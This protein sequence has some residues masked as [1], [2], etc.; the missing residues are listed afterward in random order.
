MLASASSRRVLE[1]IRRM[2][3]RARITRRRRSSRS[4]P[5]R[6]S[7]VLLPV[8]ATVGLIL[9]LLGV[10][11]ALRGLGVSSMVVAPTEEQ[12]VFIDE[13][14]GVARRLRHEVG[15]AP[16]LVTAMA[17][18]ESGW[19]QSSLTRRAH[20]YFGI[21]AEV[22]QGSMG[23]VLEP[24]QEVLGGRTITVWSRFRAYRSLEESVR[25]LGQFLHTNPR[26]ADLW[27]RAA[28][29]RVTARAL[30]GAGYATDP[31]WPDKLIRLI[32][33]YNLDALDG[34]ATTALRL[35]GEHE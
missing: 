7:G 27:P 15:L 23:D 18:N 24:T 4:V 26:Y 21:K 33:T 3:R 10:A 5:R 19:G 30:A 14:G 32:D 25:D 12:R 16:S 20:N 8:L 28:N 35:K 34:L 2:V 22:G 6:V 31:D 13:V 17:I 29:P 1:I 11:V 9:A